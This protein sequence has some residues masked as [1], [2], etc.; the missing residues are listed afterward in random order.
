MSLATLS[1]RP[2]CFQPVPCVV[3]ALLFGQPSES[4]TAFCPPAGAARRGIRAGGRMRPVPPARCA[5]RRGGF[6]ASNRAVTLVAGV[7]NARLP[8]AAP[9]ARRT[10]G[11]D[12][13]ATRQGCGSETPERGS[14]SSV[15]GDPRKGL[16]AGAPSRALGSRDVARR[17]ADRRRD[18]HSRR[19][20]QPCPLASDYA[21]S[22]AAAWP[23]G[24]FPQRWIPAS[25]GN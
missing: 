10:G 2:T 25:T 12:P 20:H 13:R 24:A 21:C 3:M 18:P 17:Q 16:L 19:G 15:G 14:R 11:G 1:A 4:V 8:S 7:R 5:A 23:S 6:P 9:A 22:R